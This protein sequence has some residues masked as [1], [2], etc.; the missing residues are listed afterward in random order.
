MKIKKY[1]CNLKQKYVIEKE[2][3]KM[4][5]KKRKVSCRTDRLK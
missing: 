4:G 1:K 5:K 3:I 2:K